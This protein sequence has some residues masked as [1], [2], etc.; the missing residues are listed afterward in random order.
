MKDPWAGSCYGMAATSILDYYDAIAFNENFSSNAATLYDVKSPS[1]DPQIMSAI[2]YYMVAQRIDFIRNEARFYYSNESNW[3]AGLKKL[4]STAQQGSPFLFCYYWL[5]YDENGKSEDHGHAIVG[6]DCKSNSDGTYSIKAYDNRYPN[7]DITINVNYNTSK[8]IVN[9]REDAYGIEIYDDMSVFDKIDIDG[10]DNDMKIR[11]ENYQYSNPNAQI[12]VEAVGNVTITNKA[13]KTIEITDG[14]VSGTMDIVSQHFIVNDN[15]D[16]TPAPATFVFE[17]ADSKM[18]TVESTSDS[19]NA[20]ITT[21]SMFA[22][23]SSDN[24]DSIVFG[25]NEGVYIIG[26]KMNYKTALSSKDTGYDTVIVEGASNKDVSL[27]YSDNNIIA[28]GIT[29]ADEKITVFTHNTDSESYTVDS[30]YR[31]VLISTDKSDNVEI[32]G[33]SKNDGNYDV[34][35]GRKESEEPVNPTASAKLKVKSSATVDYRSKVNITATASGVPKGYY[36]AIYDG[37]KLLEKGDNTKV[38][39]AP[40]DSNGKPLELKNDKTYTVKII[41]AKGNVQKDAN[42][43]DLTSK[44]EIKV[45]QGFF[46]KFIAFFKGLFGL[47]PTVEIKP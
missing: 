17:V 44:I 5:S 45:K 46:D 14:M 3:D 23:G 36:V 41:D 8:C 28:E 32:K 2:N 7:K 6:L 30:G 31:N 9:S 11:Y 27:T 25:N 37:K 12:E 22:S 1:T 35:I 34:T 39:F 43:K 13:G 16:G 47:L 38:V 20:S 26:D 24:A 29:N 15:A 42:G 40:E 19:I 10:P 33:S 18:F 21:D 4:V